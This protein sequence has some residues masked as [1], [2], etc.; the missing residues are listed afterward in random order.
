MAA[1][2]S[3]KLQFETMAGLKTWTFNYAKPSAGLT[4]V[5]ALMQSMITNGSIFEHPPIKAA[6]AKEVT[7]SENIYDLDA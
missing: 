6:S 4:N 1:G 3:L 7:T 2:T 5:R